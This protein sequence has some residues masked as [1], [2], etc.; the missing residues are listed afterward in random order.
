[1][2]SLNMIRVNCENVTN[3]LKWIDDEVEYV[4]NITEEKHC[5]QQRLEP[6]DQVDD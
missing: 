1:M 4:M 2:Y 3:S 5:L 6:L